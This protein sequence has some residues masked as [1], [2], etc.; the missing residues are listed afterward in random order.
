ME[1][2]PLQACVILTCRWSSCVKVRA[3]PWRV[4]LISALVLVLVLIDCELK[5]SS[6]YHSSNWV[7]MSAQGSCGLR[8]PGLAWVFLLFL[9]VA[10]CADAANNE[11]RSH[12]DAVPGLD[13][14]GH[15]NSTSLKKAFPV[16]SVNYD[17]VRK[18]FEISLWIL[19]AL[20]M[21]LGERRLLLQPQH[22]KRTHPQMLLKTEHSCISRLK[23]SHLKLVCKTDSQLELL[24]FFLIFHLKAATLH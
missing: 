9:L 4:A 6:G 1:L 16:L 24:F 22:D 7:K 21:K 18:P 11:T 20:L 17:Y 5:L 23:K 3:S 15:S 19:L 8:L 13:P 12:P 2:P 10:T 14:H